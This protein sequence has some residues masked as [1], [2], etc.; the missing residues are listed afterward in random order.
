MSLA[1]TRNW[2][3]DMKLNGMLGALDKALMD[4]TQLHW[5]P[6][7]LM[8]V[9]LQAEADYR[10]ERKTTNLIRAAHLKDRVALEEFDFTA[11][12]S[13]G[14]PEIK[15]IHGLEWMRQGRPLLLIGQ[16]GVGKSFIAQGAA[17]QA[18]LSGHSV[19]FMAVTDWL[20]NLAL[21]RSAGTYLKFRDKLVRPDLLVLDNFGMRKLTA[22]EAQDLCEI[23]DA[24]IG[25]RAI[26]ITSQLPLAHWSEVIPDPVIADAIRDRLEHASVKFE[27][28]GESYRAVLARRRAAAVKAKAGE[29]RG[30][31]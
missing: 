27:I 10:R 17:L 23:L 28:R 24:R 16:T 13:I 2:M 15:D 12:R 3:A 26:A 25:E 6:A 14:K 22:T 21:A 7:E 20:E 18:C 30:T 4:A 19:L 31:S 1:L 11:E 9:L 29:E 5:S 8:N